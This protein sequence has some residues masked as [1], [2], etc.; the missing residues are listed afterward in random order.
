MLA[1][2]S[3]FG[4]PSGLNIMNPITAIRTL[5]SQDIFLRVTLAGGEELRKSVSSWFQHVRQRQWYPGR[6]ALVLRV[7]ITNWDSVLQARVCWLRAA[8]RCSGGTA[9][10]S[11][12]ARVERGVGAGMSP[13]FGTSSNARMSGL[14][15]SPVRCS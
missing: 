2:A 7:L 3:F 9:R 1:R 4:A 14:L 10:P 5:R 13:P 11:F 15:P 8:W 12:H 6:M